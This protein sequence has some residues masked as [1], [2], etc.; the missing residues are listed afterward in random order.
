MELS[1]REFSKRGLLTLSSAMVVPAFFQRTAQA[2]EAT[3]SDNI[4]VLIQ[5][6]GGN[7]GLNTVVPYSDPLYYQNRPT[8]GLA[9]D[10]VLDLNGKVGLH[11][12]LTDMKTLYDEKIV[13]VVQGVGYPNA[14]RSH[15]KSTDIWTTGNPVHPEG[16]GWLGRYFDGQDNSKHPF[17]SMALGGSGQKALK[18]TLTGAPTF[19]NINS[20]RLFPDQEMGMERQADVTVQ[21]EKDVGAFKAL[22]R[23]DG[24]HFAQSGF[25]KDASMKAFVSS[26]NLQKMIGGYNSP[27]NYPNNE[28]ANQLKLVGKLIASGL[29]T[30]AYHA[31]IGGF[32][33][34]SNQAGGHAARMSQIG[35][36]LLAFMR[37]LR[38]MKKADKVVIM[39][40]SEFG[41]RVKENGSRGTDHGA[42]APLFVIGEKVK[43]GVSGD[44]PSL[45]ELDG[46][47]LKYSIDFRTV[48]TAMI[49]QWLGGKSDRVFDHQFQ[50]ASIFA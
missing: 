25:L 34:H 10:A 20:F 18:G 21:R 4:L 1:R 9:R 31:A 44:H 22:H 35:G 3:S 36:S 19:Q 48:Y 15:F 47:D 32:D 29:K 6:A 39:T 8:L 38:S 28:L 41:R 17:P 23:M 33:T 13:K 5:L 14:N 16:T 12:Q 11:P 30:R 27:V 46:G 37:D 24:G 7:D 42:A 2:L 26:E 50:A 40:Y 45:A 49:E 43:G